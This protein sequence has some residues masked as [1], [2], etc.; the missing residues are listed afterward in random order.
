MFEVQGAQARRQSGI[1]IFCF[2]PIV[3]ENT[4]YAWNNY[5]STNQGWIA[6]S[7]RVVFG[8][9]GAHQIFDYKGGPITPVIWQRNGNYDIVPSTGQFPVA[10]AWQ[11][12]AW[13]VSRN[14]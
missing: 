14:L 11:V 9:E 2:S 4:Y 7:R 3:T 8:G 10:P 12:S 1:E 5:S 13:L 6:E